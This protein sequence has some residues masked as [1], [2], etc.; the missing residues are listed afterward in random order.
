MADPR[1]D[2]TPAPMLS[3]D[4]FRH[5]AT[6]R[7]GGRFERIDGAV[8]AMAPE[9]ASHADRKALAWLALRRAIL[10]GGL[11]CHVYPDG[12]T[13]EAGDNDF[14][15]DAVLRCGAALSGDAIAV[16]DPPLLVEVL[17]PGTRGDDLTR[18]L[19]DDLRIATVRH[20]LIF[21]ADRPRVIHH[22]RDGDAWQTRIIT[23]G[24]IRLAP[25]GLTITVADIY[26]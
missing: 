22:R 8:V 24:D 23:S 5:W 11:P 16:P 20:Y 7:P 17:S 6:A 1:T 14:V 21:W 18:K 12:M 26:S 15:P 2:D 9:R 3:R 10:A 4:E 13:I 19:A 25:P